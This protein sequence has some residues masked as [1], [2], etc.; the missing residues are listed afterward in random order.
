MFYGVN[1]NV[2]N[3]KF[4]FCVSRQLCN[5][6]FIYCVNLFFIGCHCPVNC[7]NSVG[8]TLQVVSFIRKSQGQSVKLILNWL[9]IADFIIIIFENNNRYIFKL[10]VYRLFEFNGCPVKVK[11]NNLVFAVNIAFPPDNAPNFSTRIHI[12]YANRSM[13]NAIVSNQKCFFRV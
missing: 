10:V 4:H 13:Q 7:Q 6:V 11:R 2:F 1:I 5:L 3:D 9:I 12:D 8:N